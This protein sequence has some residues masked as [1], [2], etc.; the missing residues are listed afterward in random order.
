[1]A[2]LCAEGTHPHE[3]GTLSKQAEAWVL[4]TQ[5]RDEGKLKGFAFSH[6]RAHRRHAVRARRP[7]VGPPHVQARHRAARPR[8][9][10]AAPG[11]AGLPRRGRPDLRPLRP[12][13]R[14]RR[15]PLPATTSS[16]G[17]AT[18]PRARS[19]PGAAAWP[20]ATA[21]RPGAYDQ[22]AFLAKGDGSGHAAVFDH[23]TPAPRADRRRGGRAVRRPAP[24]QG[25]QPRR[26]SAGPWK[27]TCA[28]SPESRAEACRGRGIAVD[29]LDS[30]RPQ[31][32]RPACPRLTWSSATPSVPATW[33]G[34]SPTPGRR[35]PSSTS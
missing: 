7:G 22:R 30:G 16:R 8:A 18:G 25:R 4:I 3:V 31:P 2:D 6:P 20:S 29:Q 9:G 13:G 15:L 12:A 35:R 19:G 21:S 5:V 24:P 17:P 34:P 1:M 11:R 28:S 23:E 32:R 33:C 10:P 14:V 27:R 26:R